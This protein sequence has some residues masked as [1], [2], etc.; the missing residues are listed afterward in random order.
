MLVHSYY[1][2]DPR[3]RREAEWLAGNGR[4][5]DVYA[6]RRSTDAPA[7]ITDGV[8]V[9]R[10]DVQR[11]QGASPIRYV[12][13]YLSFLLR[14]A[15]ALTA[16]H[17]TRRYALVQVHTIPDFLVFA[18]LHFRLA[19]IPVILDVHEAMPEFFKLRFP[20]AANPLIHAA[21]MV[22]ERA[23]IGA[24]TAVI[25]ANEGLQAR[26]LD[27]GVPAW[28]MRLVRNTAD[29]AR[30]DAM[31]HPRRPFMAD[32]RLRLVYAGALTPI[33]EVDVAIEAVA[34]LRH[35]HPELPIDLHLYG[36]GDSADAL[37]Q[38]A[39]D[40]GVAEAVHFHGRIPIED[41]PAAVA[42]ADIGLA[43]TRRA[44]FTDYSLSTKIFE[45]AAMGKPVVASRLPLVEQSLD[46]AVLTYEPGSA[47][48]LAARIRQVVED[49]GLRERLIARA[50]ERVRNLSWQREAVTYG[51]LIEEFA[52]D[53]RDRGTGNASR[54]AGTVSSSS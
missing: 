12:A 37:G 23:S 20:A 19:G 28:K 25:P 35:V 21:L 13:E 48:D 7:G 49:A 38:Q 52:S 16:A 53:G 5:V 26:L 30:F 8:N 50:A 36:R 22:Q 2:E 46:D 54:D 27:L 4:E 42:R 24:A 15:A 32:G 40:L 14:A 44:Q 31:R 34:A 47:A 43:P 39:A 9:R 29:L 41:V 45:Y 3:V 33:Y 17:R 51:A 6:L 18:A 1:D 10:L 11:H